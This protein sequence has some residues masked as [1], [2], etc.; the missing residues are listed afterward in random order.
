MCAQFDAKIHA[1]YLSLKFG[2]TIPNDLEIRI[3]PYSLSPVIIA[4][5]SSN[6]LRNMNFSL[7]PSWSKERKVKFATHNARL[8]S[9]PDH[10]NIITPIYKRPTWREPFMQKHCL[11]LIS[12]FIEPIYI[13]N[14]AGNM[15]KFSR[16][17]S[18]PLVAAGI[19]DEWINKENGEIIESFAIL[20][21][22][23]PKFVSE[24]GHDRCPIFL[25]ESSFQA[26]LKPA[27]KE[28]V[29]LVE[30][31]L[32]NQLKIDFD[33]AIDRALKPGWEKRMSKK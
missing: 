1:N 12:G 32:E 33:V 27:T 28:P 22:D 16:K 7:I 13:N 11:V 26:W 23:P 24:I 18:D 14:Y 17:G 10:K 8:F 9:E 5:N 3:L 20:T 6:T 31:L 15:V 21:H 4:E 19:W 2:I 29:K 30:F 25:S